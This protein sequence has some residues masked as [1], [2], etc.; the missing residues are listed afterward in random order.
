MRDQLGLRY[1]K[2][3]N[4]APQANSDRC[5]IQRQQCSIELLKLMQSKS[6]IIQIDESWVDSCDYR[7]RSWQRKGMSNSIPVK[8]VRPRITM[9]VA[10]SS[11]GEIYCSLLQANSD[12]D[13]M[14]LFMNELII[15]LDREDK[16]WRRNTVLVWDGAGYHTTKETMAMLED[17]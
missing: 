12:S 10:L 13:T 17:Y 4:V 16:D 7:R 3:I 14:R 2:I 1:S 15:R 11:R 5:R 9:I 6:R 8:K